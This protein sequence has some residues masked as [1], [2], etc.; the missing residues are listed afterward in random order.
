MIPVQQRR[1]IARAVKLGL[2]GLAF[3]VVLAWVAEKRS[4]RRVD[5]RVETR[6]ERVGRSNARVATAPMPEIEALVPGDAAIFNQD[7]AVALILHGDQLHAGLSPQMRAKIEREIMQST[8]DETTGFGAAVA[9]V[10]RTTVASAIGTHAIYSLHDIRL[11]EVENGQIVLIQNNGRRVELLGDVK[12]DDQEISRT[13][14]PD[15]AR[16]F[17]DAVRARM[18]E[19]RGMR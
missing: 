19:L 8:S 10:V 12:S 9:N 11:I 18:R 5:V 16:R 2:V 7:S 17:V 14:S 6:G 13:F 1:W 15:E 3:V 4:D